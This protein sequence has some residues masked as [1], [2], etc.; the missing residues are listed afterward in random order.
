MTELLIK[1]L[2]ERKMPIGLKPVGPNPLSELQILLIWIRTHRPCETK[3]RRK[4]FP[5][6]DAVI[7]GLFGGDDRAFRVWLVD[8][9]GKL[10]GTEKEG[11]N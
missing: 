9:L 4:E 5:T 3:V 10:L 8:C 11:E 1:E 2:Y 7:T 6:I